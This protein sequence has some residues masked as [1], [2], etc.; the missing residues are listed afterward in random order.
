[1]QAQPALLLLFL[2]DQEKKAPLPPCTDPPY[3]RIAQAAEAYDA[4]GWQSFTGE[5]EYEK[6]L[7]NFEKI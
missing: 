5:K 2:G 7:K 1:M 6:K 3:G 4:A